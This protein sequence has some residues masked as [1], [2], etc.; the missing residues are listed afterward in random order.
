[1]HVYG[2]VWMFAWRCF[3]LREVGGKCNAFST[4]T[5]LKLTNCCGFT[6]EH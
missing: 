1:M 4:M 2:T 3:K 5:I 6:G